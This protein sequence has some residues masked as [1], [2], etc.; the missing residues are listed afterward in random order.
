[1]RTKLKEQIGNR[2]FSPSI[3][4]ET[5][6]NYSQGNYSNQL[7]QESDNNDNIN[8]NDNVNDNDNDNDNDKPEIP[9]RGPPSRYLKAKQDYERAVEKQMQM[10][11]MMKKKDSPTLLK[12]GKFA[13]PNANVSTNATNK[14]RFD[15]GTKRNIASVKTPRTDTLDNA[16]SNANTN[17]N[18]KEELL[19]QETDDSTNVQ[20]QIQSKSVTRIPT[21]Y[22][23]KMELQKAR[24]DRISMTPSIPSRYASHMKD[25]AKE[26]NLKN[27][28]TLSELRR[29]KEANSLDVENQRATLLQLKQIRVEQKLKEKEDLKQKALVGKKETEIKKIMESNDLTPFQKLLRVKHMSVSNSRRIKSVS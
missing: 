20:V 26:R 23:N 8:D 13:G 21:K 9:K 22:A 29:V 11:A 24:D 16:N 1:M 27:V 19:D 25:E 18:A 17:T 10:Q 2:S 12:K 15:T 28:K 3:E 6:V 14:S 4:N 7:R 5:P